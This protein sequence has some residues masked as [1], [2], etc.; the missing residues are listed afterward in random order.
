MNF[1]TELAA[2]DG[3]HIAAAVGI[4]AL[5]LIPLIFFVA[6]LVSILRSPLTGGMRLVWIVFA[7][8]APFLGPLLWFLAGRRTAEAEGPAASAG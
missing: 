2:T 7:F 4:G 3:A 8:C 1:P 6:A 5:C